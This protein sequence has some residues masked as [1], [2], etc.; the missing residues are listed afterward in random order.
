MKANSNRDPLIQERS[1]QNHSSENNEIKQLNLTRIW[2][3]VSDLLSLCLTGSLAL[4]IPFL[5]GRNI[6]NKY[7]WLMLLLTILLILIYY[8]NH[9]YP[10]I[11]LAPAI[12][13]K[14]I[15]TA[16][17]TGM[18]LIT[19]SLFIFQKGL[20]YSRMVFLLFWI[21]ACF[22]VPLARI[23][24]RK[25]GLFLKTWGEPVAIIGSGCEIWELH[26]HLENNRLFGF[27]PKLLV[28]FDPNPSLRAADL[29]QV[30]LINGE[31]LWEHKS[32]LKSMG[33]TTGFILV[34][35]LP[36]NLRDLILFEEKLC[37]QHA[38][39]ISEMDSIGGASIMP[40][41]L[42]GILGLE[43][44][45]DFFKR[46]N[47]WMKSGIN[48]IITALCFPFLLPVFAVI[49]LVIWLDSPGAVFFSQKRIG[50][51]GKQFTMWKFRTMV[52][53]ADQLLSEYLK[54]NLNL[55]E[56]W[57]ENHKLKDDPRVTRVGKFLRR[58]SL[59]ELPQFW[60]VLK[61]DMSLVGPRPIVADE[62]KN[63][64][65]AFRMY[66]K[67]KPGMT[68]LW[69]VKGR[70]NSPYKNRV[71]LDQ[72]YVRHWSLWLD[73][74]ILLETVYTVLMKIGAY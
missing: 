52:K 50:Y 9:L 38:I 73:V 72:Y 54:T 27:I 24:A 5:L 58:T 8:L 2:L 74:I 61:G 71:A 47:R 7:Y 23:A 29:D 60:N 43:V 13:I 14:K 69:Q 10:G 33:I 55:Q 51:Q 44:R 48:Y 65:D 6:N 68:G 35:N 22:T 59:D 4:I 46:R 26:Q 36:F 30:P 1:H 28:D 49:S 18:A 17:S 21:F 16:T 63:Y 67:V 31:F 3:L 40:Y 41:D 37:I 64:G 39:L 25:I 11:G 53:D 19:I 56:E 57:E 12:E 70:N 34:K 20:Q 66:Q 15:T 42:Q 45:R 32:L 62:I